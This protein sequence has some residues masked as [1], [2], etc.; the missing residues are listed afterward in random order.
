MHRATLQ[1]PSDATIA[2]L[3]RTRPLIFTQ[4]RLIFGERRAAA[5]L[6][7]TRP[8]QKAMA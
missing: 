3:E 6:I 5:I 4:L 7:A 8:G 1:W 2:I